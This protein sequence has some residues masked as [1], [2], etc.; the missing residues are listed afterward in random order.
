MKRMPRHWDAP[1]VAWF[2]DG[3]YVIAGHIH[4]QA[5]V[6]GVPRSWPVFWLKPGMT[7]LPAFPAFT[8]GQRPDIERGDTLIACVDEVAIPIQ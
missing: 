8:G 1:L 2:Q 7:I 3:R 5:S 6:P 4:P